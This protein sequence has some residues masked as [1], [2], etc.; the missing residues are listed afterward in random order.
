MSIMFKNSNVGME[1]ELAAEDYKAHAVRNRVAI[2]AV[3]LTTILITVIFTV[4]F[5]LVRTA[6]LSV[7]A[8]PGPGADG[9]CVYGD[10]EILEK[11]RAL[12][13]VEWAAFARRCSSTY[14]HNR[15]FSSVETRLFAA[16]DVHYEKNMVDLIVG[17]YPEGANELLVSDT[18]SERLGLGEEVGIPYSLVVVIREN[19]EDVEKEIPMV[20]CGYY[21]N[22]I[23]NVKDIYEEVYTDESFIDIYNPKLPSGRDSIYVK[24]NNLEFFKFGYDKDE[25]LNEVAD[26]SGAKGKEYKMSDMSAIF[27]IP[28]FLIVL[29]IM[30][31]GYFFIYNIFD[32]SVMNDIR[33]YGE[34]KT[35]GMTS[36]QLRRM[37]FL[38][39]NR[40][41]FVGILAGSLIGFGVGNASGGIIVSLFADGIAGYYQKAGIVEIF[42][43]SAVF[44]WLTIYISTMKPFKIACHISP[45]EAARYGGK[46]KKGVFSVLSFALSGILF[47]VVYTLPMGY[48]VDVMRERYNETDFRITHRGSLWSIDEAYRPISKELVEKLAGLPFVENFRVYYQARTKPDYIEMDGEI[49]MYLSSTGEIAKDGEIAHDIEIYNEKI[50]EGSLE[51]AYYGISEN[52]R[53]NYRVNVMGMDAGYL[54]G[55]EKYFQMIEGEMDAEKFARG[56]YVIY[57]RSNENGNV[58]SGKKAEYL[59]HAGDE[60]GITFYDDVTDSYIKK[61]FTVM[62]VITCTDQFGTSNIAYGNLILTDEVFRSIYSDYGNC[63]SRVSFDISESEAGEKETAVLEREKERYDAVWRI[64]EEDGNLQLYFQSKYEAG[65]D[66]ME[67]KRVM[68]IIG[69]FLAGI[70]GLIG[71][72]NVVNTVSTDVTA[73]RLEYAAMQSIGMTKKQMEKDIFGKYARY[74]FSAVILAAVVG[75]PLTYV[76]GMDALFTGI[77]MKA[78][79]QAMAMFLSFSFLLCAAMAHV[80]AK[81]LNRKSI[82]ERLREVV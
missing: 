6:S 27:L 5:S 80:L 66:A 75:M 26:L 35:I 73:R 2:L 62:A 52:Q 64:I 22:P 48:N 45:V 43:A 4:G 13:Q 76:L 18:M 20:I 68:G 71:I 21:S 10:Y 60:V 14:L 33:F 67:E 65:Q 7:S 8:S 46:R 78:F 16:D 55:E 17:K 81:A 9:S 28:V 36:R 40:I 47:L 19:G 77:S 57:Q 24:L 50:E 56:N 53:G 42:L 41:A 44:S 11:V 82:V 79:L 3:M 69:M 59:V 63:I 74:I 51:E 49:V 72:F 23:R 25:K 12:P 38:Q 39:M 61:D 34:V 30:F 1:K 29:L 37:L 32:I 58:I 70:V 15:E 31:C 54:S